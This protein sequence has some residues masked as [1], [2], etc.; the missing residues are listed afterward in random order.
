MEKA[1]MEREV[2]TAASCTSRAI[3]ALRCCCRIC[4]CLFFPSLWLVRATAED[5]R[6]ADAPAK[7]AELND[8]KIGKLCKYASKN[9]LRI[10]KVIL[11]FVT[12]M[13][14]CIMPLY[15]SSLLAIIRTLLEQ[16][17]TDEIRILGCNTL[18]DFIEC[19]TDGTYVFNLEGFILKLCQLA[20][21]VGEDERALHLRSAGLQA[22]SYM[23][24]LLALVLPLLLEI[25]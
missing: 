17:R 19:Q 22:L 15:A 13:F 7:E 11:F 10:P 5:F 1:T 24:L 4:R 25:A 6:V 21:E 14:N 12:A 9:P 16:S 2:A 8:R 18:V 23:V 3:S 20:Q